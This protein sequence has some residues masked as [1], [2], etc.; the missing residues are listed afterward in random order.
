MAEVGEE[1]SKN[2][3]FYEVMK[4]GKSMTVK[5]W[6]KDQGLTDD[7]ENLNGWRG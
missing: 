4:N 3:F 1:D 2:V 7:H 5:E 6:Y